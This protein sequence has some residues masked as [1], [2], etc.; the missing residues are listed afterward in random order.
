MS[1]WRFTAA[2][3]LPASSAVHWLWDGFLPLG[4]VSVLGGPAGAGKS[5]LVAG[6]E[7]AVAAG[8]P[9]LEAAVEQ[10][11][12]WHADYDTDARLQGPWYAKVARGM[13]AGPAALER[14]RYMEPENPA[15]GLGLDELGELEQLVRLGPPALLVL[16]AW[17][18]AFFYADSRKAEHVAEV[19]LRL[20]QIA[21][22]GPA[23]LIIDHTPKPVQGLGPLER[24]VAGSFY[25]LGGARAAYLLQRV[26][27]KLTAGLDVLRLDCLKNNL[28]PMGEPL[29]IARHFERD[30]LAFEL[31]DLPEE[32]QTRAPALSRAERA[33]R[34]ALT[35]G[36]LLRPELVRR[37]AE[38]A[39]V[40]A[41]TITEALRRLKASGEVEAREISGKGSPALYCLPFAVN[42][43]KHDNEASDLAQTTLPE[44]G[45]FAL[46]APDTWETE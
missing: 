26:A 17:T 33:I 44:M 42:G 27:P 21:A 20:R 37:V 9:F 1:A 31:T 3:D 19:M 15:R 25:K 7:V 38:R 32:E 41:R 11:E 16:D 6:L 45:E 35:E 29:G 5:S 30:S 28:G 22:L 40:S 14:I 36:P 10:G 34:E 8:L 12:V 46:N 23:V 39:N 18:S 43:Q 24:G 13:G 4:A 2:R